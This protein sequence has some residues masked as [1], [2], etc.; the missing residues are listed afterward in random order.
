MKGHESTI[1]DKLNTWSIREYHLSPYKKDTL[2]I[3]SLEKNVVS[4]LEG[5]P[6]W[7][8]CSLSVSDSVLSILNLPGILIWK[9]SM[10]LQLIAITLLYN[11]SGT[12]WKMRPA[13]VDFFNQRSNRESTIGES[14]D[15]NADGLGAIRHQLTQSLMPRNKNGSMVGGIHA[16]IIPIQ[17]ALNCGCIFSEAKLHHSLFSQFTNRVWATWAYRCEIKMCLTWTVHWISSILVNSSN[18]NLFWHNILFKDW[19]CFTDGVLSTVRN[20]G[21]VLY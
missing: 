12:N 18:S 17:P 16:W 1:I 14:R 6:V 8:S 10:K 2:L 3:C 9:L 15:S 19:C 7:F 20:C 13:P 4:P 21:S 11:A 5:N